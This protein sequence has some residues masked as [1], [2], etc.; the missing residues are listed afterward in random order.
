MSSRLSGATA[1]VF[2][3][4]ACSPVSAQSPA[5][6]PECRDGTVRVLPDDTLSRIASRCD[7]SEGS[8][9][10]ANPNIDG[11]A[12][13][14][15]GGTLRLQP[16][17][18]TAQRLKDNLNGF[19]RKADDALGRFAGQ[20]GASAQ[21]L[22]D[23]NPDLK[24]RLQRLGQKV[25]LTDDDGAPSLTVTPEHGVAGTTV[26]LAATGLPKDR[27]VIV[28]AGA[29]GNAYDV[30]RESRTTAKGTFAAEVRV[31]SRIDNGKVVFTLRA[32]DGDKLASAPFTVSP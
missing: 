12:D 6:Q 14:Q 8:L 24:A 28:G 1:L 16:Q 4:W 27:P 25:G 22:L 19:A 17:P 5:Q 15:V 30:V 29:P 13:L 20:V 9:L 31:P 23:K 7:V 18:G 2:L 32:T 10:A 11:S 3:V 26:T 21:D